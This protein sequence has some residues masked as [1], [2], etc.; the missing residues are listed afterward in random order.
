MEQHDETLHGNRLVH[1]QENIHRIRRIQ[2]QLDS[3]AKLL[4]ADEGSCEDRVIRARTVEKGVTSLIN[5][6]VTCYVDNTL[7]YKMQDEPEEAG[8]ELSRLL[9]LLNK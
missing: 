9:K 8:A 4:E 7:K 1:N 3:L 2:G 5:H 6:L